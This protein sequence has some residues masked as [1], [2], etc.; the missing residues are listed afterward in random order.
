MKSLNRIRYEM[1]KTGLKAC[2]S[3]VD[4]DCVY[5]DP[6]NLMNSDPDPGQ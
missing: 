6:Q 1:L 3:D 4:P 2:D 5:P